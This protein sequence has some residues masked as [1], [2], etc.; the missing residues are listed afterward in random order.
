RPGAGGR[1]QVGEPRNKV[2]PHEWGKFGPALAADVD[3]QALPAHPLAVAAGGCEMREAAGLFARAAT[4]TGNASDR[5]RT[6]RARSFQGASCH[7]CGRLAAHRAVA[8]ERS[9]R[10]PK[11]VF[12][13]LI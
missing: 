10:N 13:R 11:Q 12:F 9:S 4:W 3:E 8:A 7:C 5:D 1:F 2:E 6:I